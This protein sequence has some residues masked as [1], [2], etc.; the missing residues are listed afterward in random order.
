MPTYLTPLVVTSLAALIAATI[1]AIAFSNR[2]GRGPRLNAVRVLGTVY[3]VW[4]PVMIWMAMDEVFRPSASEVSA[5]LPLAIIGPPLIL[6][7]ALAV[8]PALRRVADGLSQDWLIGIQMLRVMGGVFVLVWAGG[9]MPWEFALPAGLGDVAVGL[10]AMVALN[11]LRHRAASAAAWVR[12]TN[13]A[14]LADFAVAL[15][16]GFLSAPG[17]IQLLALDRPNEL[18]NLYPLVLIPVFA[19]PV[20]I[21]VHILSIRLHL[22]RRA[23]VGGGDPVPA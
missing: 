2:L 4:L 17:A 8:S 23:E 15:G 10:I 14:G 22:A 3:A 12:R 6:L 1:A 9:A 16:T 5:V 19:V 11:R 13:I 21:G 18:I 20:F 7:A